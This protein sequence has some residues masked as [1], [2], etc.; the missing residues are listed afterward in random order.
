VQ[1]STTSLG[2]CLMQDFGT[3]GVVLLLEADE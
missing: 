1:A 3:L 2:G